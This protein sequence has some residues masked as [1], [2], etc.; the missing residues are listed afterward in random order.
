MGLLDKIYEL[1]LARSY[2]AH[3]GVVEAVRELLQNAIDSES[4]LEYSFQSGVLSIRSRYATL[5]AS[6]LLLG[7]TSKAD[8][9]QKVGQ[10][11]EGYKIALL[12]LTREGKQVSVRNGDRLWTPE[13]KRSRAFG[14]EV[15][16]IRESPD[17]SNKGCGLEFVI[18]LLTDDDEDRIRRS[19]LP[20]QEQVGEIVETSKGQILLDR[21]GELY[22][23]GLYVC[24]TKLWYG[25]NV[26]PEFLRLERDRN[27]VDSFDL[28]WLAK[29]MW[30]ESK[31][32]SQVAE[33][34]EQGCPDLEHVHYDAPEIVKEAC[35]KLFKQQHPGAVVAINNKELERAVK[36]GMTVY[37]YSGS[38]GHVLQNDPALCV[39]DAGPAPAPVEALRAFFRAHRGEMRTP[40]IVAF[41]AL[42][43]SSTNW[44]A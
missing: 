4:P 3:W 39:P 43:E 18:D 15:L 31:R 1:P 22:V 35:Y 23:K 6:S 17:P 33:L 38:Y 14:T 11:G 36:G 41:K 40:A 16:A 42:I 20:M 7:T 13:F 27:T 12:V 26:K 2:V 32:M 19:F 8:N 34:M 5:P 44:K 25:Y 10:F 29:Q 9:A 24:Q 28:A 21:P 37:S 30:Y